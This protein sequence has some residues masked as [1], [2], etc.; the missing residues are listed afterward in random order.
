METNIFNDSKMLGVAGA[1]WGGKPQQ[2]K[3]HSYCI[4]SQEKSTRELLV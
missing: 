4:E 1:G 2:I 3:I